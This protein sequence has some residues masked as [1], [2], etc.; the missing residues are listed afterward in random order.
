MKKIALITLALIWISSLIIL[1]IALTDLYP[2]NPFKEY[3][4]SVGIGFIAITGF[5]KIAYK[6]IF[7]TSSIE[8]N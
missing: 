2:N 5:L 8:K 4:L 1:I 6:Q 7:K 3:R